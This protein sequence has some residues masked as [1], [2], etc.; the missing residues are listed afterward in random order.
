MGE[1]GKVRVCESCI[2]LSVK[3]ENANVN[4]CKTLNFGAFTDGGGW[5]GMC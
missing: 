3:C 5:K 1:G 4:S 2:V